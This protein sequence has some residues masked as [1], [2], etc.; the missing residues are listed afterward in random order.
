[1][2]ALSVN[3]IVVSLTFSSYM[4]RNVNLIIFEIIDVPNYWSQAKMHYVSGI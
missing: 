3:H 4:F 2:E 1:M